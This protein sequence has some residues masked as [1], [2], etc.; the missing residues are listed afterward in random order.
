[1][2]QAVELIHADNGTDMAKMKIGL[3]EA[4]SLL[5]GR[6]YKKDG[7]HRERKSRKSDDRLIRKVWNVQ[8]K[9]T[10]QKNLRYWL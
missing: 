2:G 1:M 10:I 4:F 3:I 7:R 9:N 5:C 8:E 6:G